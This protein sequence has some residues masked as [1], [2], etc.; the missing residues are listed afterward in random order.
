MSL[1]HGDC[2]DL[3]RTSNTLRTLEANHFRRLFCEGLGRHSSISTTETLNSLTSGSILS[4]LSLP[5]F[6]CQLEH[7]A[8]AQQW[9]Y[10]RHLR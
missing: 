5:I 9:Y 1:G 3:F 8:V 7:E 10:A 2:S 6:P 4:L